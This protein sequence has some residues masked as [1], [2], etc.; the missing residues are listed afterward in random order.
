MPSLI[1]SFRPQGF[2][3]GVGK[4]TYNAGSSLRLLSAVLAHVKRRLLAASRG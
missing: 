1:D 3:R 2:N 4:K